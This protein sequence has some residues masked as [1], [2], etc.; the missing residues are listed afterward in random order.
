MAIMLFK[1][2]AGFIG[3]SSRQLRRYELEGRLTG[4]NRF[5]KRI[6]VVNTETAKVLPPVNRVRRLD[7]FVIGRSKPLRG[8]EGFVEGQHKRKPK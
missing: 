7:G 6:A 4:V 5:N 2:Y 8:D 3:L 1:D